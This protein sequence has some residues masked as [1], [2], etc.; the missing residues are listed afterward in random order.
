MICL[1]HS[2]KRREEKISQLFSLRKVWQLFLFFSYMFIESEEKSYCFSFYFR[3][4]LLLKEWESR[5][6]KWDSF[7]MLI[8]CMNGINWWDPLLIWESPPHKRDN[9]ISLLNFYQS[10]SRSL[11]YRTITFS[12]IIL[13]LLSFLSIINKLDQHSFLLFVLPFSLSLITSTIQGNKLL[14]I[15]YSIILM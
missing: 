4:C 12:F 1:I 10:H 15:F 11:F 7:A 8:K 14:F 5:N 2:K 13:Y 3:A 6:K 9:F